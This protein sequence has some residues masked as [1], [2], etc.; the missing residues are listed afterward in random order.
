MLC[1]QFLYWEMETRINQAEVS[2][3]YLRREHRG[4]PGSSLSL[5]PTSYLSPVDGWVKVV[6]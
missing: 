6:S 3:C 5:I 2:Q 1:P 4:D